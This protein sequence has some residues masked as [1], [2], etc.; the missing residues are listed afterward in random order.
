MRVPRG[1]RRTVD[2][3]RVGRF[4][5]GLDGECAGVEA[6]GVAGVVA[7]EP[8]LMASLSEGLMGLAYGAENA[9]I[10]ALRQGVLV[11]WPV[12]YGFGRVEPKAAWLVLFI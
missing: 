3:E 8:E 10:W 2:L 11:C 12:A 7:D 9:E 6:G 5:D 4:C 1:R